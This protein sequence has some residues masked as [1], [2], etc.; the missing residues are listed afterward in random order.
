MTHWLKSF[1]T[2]TQCKAIVARP[3]IVVDA[4][5]ASQSPHATDHDEGSALDSLGEAAR[6]LGLEESLTQWCIQQRTKLERL[7]REYTPEHPGDGRLEHLAIYLMKCK[8][9]EQTISLAILEQVVDDI[10]TQEETWVGEEGK[11]VRDGKGRDGM[12][13]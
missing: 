11:D 13:G 3:D 12:H 7:S 6:S 10:R 9:S 1:H 5:S 8:A 2:E 4:E